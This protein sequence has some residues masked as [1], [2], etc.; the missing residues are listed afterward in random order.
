MPR[1]DSTPGRSD[2]TIMQQFIILICSGAIMASAIA[3]CSVGTRPAQTQP[4]GCFDVS[5]ENGRFLLSDMNIDALE[6]SS[7]HAAGIAQENTEGF[8][9]SLQLKVSSKKPVTATFRSCDFVY[10]VEVKHEDVTAHQ[11][12]AVVVLPHANASVDL[13]LQ[14]GR[15]PVTI[16]QGCGRRFSGHDQQLVLIATE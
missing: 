3:V 16:V 9:E 14:P 5:I 12:V 13:N 1:N 8:Q 11:S 2:N 7:K 15:W 10:T 4:V 6:N